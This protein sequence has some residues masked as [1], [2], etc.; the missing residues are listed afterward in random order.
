[1][2]GAGGAFVAF[3]G[4]LLAMFFVPL[5]IYGTFE[6]L[7][8]V[9]LPQDGSPWRFMLSVLVIKVGVAM[10]FV[11]LFRLA[12]PGLR[13]RS[14]PYAAIWWV[15]FAIIEAGQAIGPGYSAAEAVAGVISEAIYFPLSAALVARALREKRRASDG[16]RRRRQ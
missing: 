6:V 15:M 14:W 9:E 16:P 5:P 11:L 3:I 8:W 10:A 1:M 7:G 2:T 12:R 4:T 13:G